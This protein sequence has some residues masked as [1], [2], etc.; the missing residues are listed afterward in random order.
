VHPMKSAVLRKGPLLRE[1]ALAATAGLVLTVSPFT[2]NELAPAAAMGFVLGAGL[3]AWRL[4]PQSPVW[5]EASEEAAPWALGWDRVLGVGVALLCLAVFAPTLQWMYL[6]WTRSLWSNQHG[7]FVPF[8]MAWLA[9]KALRDDHGPAE[10]SAWGLVPFGLG[11]MLAALDANAQTRYLAAFGLV[12][13]LPGLSLLLLGPRRTRALRVPLLIALLLIPIPYTVGTPLALRTIT[14][15]GVLPLLHLLGYT[16]LREGTQLI[17]PRQ[18]F[19]VADACSGV[20]TL[21][22][23]LATAL[24]LAALATDRWRRSVL[25]LSAPLLA[26]ACNIVR[27]TLLVVLA[28]VFGTELLDTKLHEASGVVTFFVVLRVLF[29]MA[30]GPW[31]ARRAA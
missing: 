3:L 27:V 9:R 19:L 14:A 7:L 24:V 8:A 10:S 17:M 5:Q 6:E 18:N 11:L 4:R 13:A 22:A 16:V 30:N 28:Q 23:S 2:P 12:L 15:T 29:W 25:I 1:L 21:Y 31:G 26:I 20:A